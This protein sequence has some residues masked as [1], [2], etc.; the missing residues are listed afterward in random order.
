MPLE[1]SLIDDI[2]KRGQNVPQVT[3]TSLRNAARAG[4]CRRFVQGVEA[5]A[6]RGALSPPPVPAWLSRRLLQT[7]SVRTPSPHTAHDG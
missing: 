2:G 4:R 1:W 7:P 5:A 6:W 3:I